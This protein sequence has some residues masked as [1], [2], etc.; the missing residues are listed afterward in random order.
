[1]NMPVQVRIILGIF[2]EKLAIVMEEKKKG[3]NNN[4]YMTETE[5]QVNLSISVT[6]LLPWER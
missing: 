3:I 2:T 1:M 4:R 6:S 5:T